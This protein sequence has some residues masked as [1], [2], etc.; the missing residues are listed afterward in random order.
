[1]VLLIA[2]ISQFFYYECGL[3]NLLKLFYSL[4]NFGAC[5]YDV[6]REPQHTCI[7]ASRPSLR[8]WKAN[9]EGKVLETFIFKDDALLPSC[10][11]SSG[12]NSSTSLSSKLEP[13][14]G[15]VLKFMEDFLVSWNDSQ[16]YVI[17]VEDPTIF[18][19]YGDFSNIS[20]VAVC[21]DEIFL[22]DGLRNIT[23]I[24]RSSDHSVSPGKVSF[25]S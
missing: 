16:L 23:R 12:L 11:I 21:K 6:P 17:T 13:Q 18:L 3:I 20:S 10:N 19:K 14:F 15:I 5:F 24:A 8:L 22:L 1:M 25:G 9:V 7:Y 2:S 4:G